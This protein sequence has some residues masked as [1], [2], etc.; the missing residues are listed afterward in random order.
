MRPLFYIE[1]K[2]E[3]PQNTIDEQVAKHILQWQYG[4]VNTVIYESCHMPHAAGGGLMWEDENGEQYRKLPAWSS[5]RKLCLNVIDKMTANNYAVH[6][7]VIGETCFCEFSI[8]SEVVGYHAD[9]SFPM[10]VCKAALLAK[11]VK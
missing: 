7:N 5:D 11:G 8:E 1:Q 3:P 6:I 4:R 2:L 9:S 10:S